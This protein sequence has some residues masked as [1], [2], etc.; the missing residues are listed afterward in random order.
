MSESVWIESCWW[1]LNLDIEDVD[2]KRLQTI[3]V[4]PTTSFYIVFNPCIVENDVLGENWY[5]GWKWNLWVNVYLVLDIDF[6]LHGLRNNLSQGLDVNL[7]NQVHSIT[8]NEFWK[9][10]TFSGYIF[11]IPIVCV[12]DGMAIFLGVESARLQNK[13]WCVL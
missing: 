9:V 4:S 2:K 10:L 13:T 8:G 7:C 3:Y 6:K 12:H 5:E 11:L 1:M